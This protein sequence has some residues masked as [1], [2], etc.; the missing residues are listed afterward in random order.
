M[1]AGDQVLHY[2]ILDKI[3]GGG[4]GL[5]FKAEDIRLGRY[6][7][8]KFLSPELSR[9][10]AANERF[11]REARA[12]SALNHANI[13]T[14]YDVGE[15]E[16]ENFIAMEFLEGTTLKHQIDRKPLTM[17]RLL[18]LAIQITDALDSAHSGGIIHRDIKPANIFVTQRRQAKLLDFGLAKLQPQR[19]LAMQGAGETTAGWDHPT[20]PGTTLGTVAYMSPEQAKGEDLDARTDLFSFGVV[21]YEMATGVQAFKGTTSAVIFDAILNHAPIAPVR[22][23]PKLPARLEEI[24]NK[25]LEKDRDLRYQN[26]AEFRADLKRL[27]RD[28]RQ[29]SPVAV[30]AQPEAV[31]P[32]LNQPLPSGDPAHRE[33]STRSSRKFWIVALAAFTLAALGLGLLAGTRLHA[34]IPPVYQPLTFRRGTIWNARF[35]ADPQSI[36]YGAAWEGSPVE[37]FSA[38]ADSPESRPIGVT[39][40]DLLDIS[41][42]GEMALELGSHNRDGFIRSGTL[43]RVPL[44]GG[45]PR[46]ILD[47]VEAATWAPDGS[48]PAVVRYV[49]GRERLEFP[50]GKVLYDSSGWIA[51]IRFSPDGNTIAFVDHPLTRDDGGS[52]N[53]IDKSGNNRKILSAGW[54]SVRGLAWSPS[55]KEIWFGAT[56]DQAAGEIHAVNLSGSERL[57]ERTPIQ[58]TLQDIA[59]DGHV[60]FDTMTERASILARAPGLQT[61]R[62]LGWHD[63]SVVRDIGNDGKL[64]L[65]I[66][67][68]AAGGARY[69]AYVRSTDGSPAV[70]ISDGVAAALSPD[71]KSALVFDNTRVGELTIFPIGTGEPV[72]M[73]LGSIIIEYACWFPDGRR[74]LV[75]GNEPGRASRL[76]VLDSPQAKPRP[77]A[78]EGF[79]T[80]WN[81]ISPDGRFIAVVDP[82][83]KVVIYPL[84]G[85]TADSARPVPSLQPGELPIRWSID[86]QWI[87]VTKPTDIPTKVFLVNINTGER[88]LMMSLEPADRTGLDTTSS[89]RISPD[90]KSYAYSYER[91][92]SQLYLATGLK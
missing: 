8:L 66:E 90:G 19:Q 7:A 38:R 80:A 51:D 87:Y 54:T 40:A 17:E 68:G 63:W 35:G 14:I 30:S 32:G 82:E 60:L 83:Q 42:K 77:I 15:F 37:V 3:G 48:Q 5:V 4:M 29:P 55:G 11:R 2:R 34:T 27:Q 13:C 56:H 52:V 73:N 72:R 75:S 79:A 76:Y 84:G 31:E 91:F 24:I 59:A 22:L 10:S 85:T 18:D 71:A 46:P 47:G 58:L 53:I 12:A 20:N 45:A 86:P 69:A 74:I 1:A 25:A 36:V 39:G 65:F 61:E 44:A 9:D 28:L 70:R 49:A 50:I 67:A 16:G 88:K 57:V 41:S 62:E 33:L 92:L 81:T 6:V 43:A 23:N 26:A 21:L 64:I 89:L 78:L